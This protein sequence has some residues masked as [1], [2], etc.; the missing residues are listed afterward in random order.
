[1][2]A[3]LPVRQRLAAHRA[4]AT[5]ASCHNL[6][7][8]IGLALENFDAVGRW[9]DVE[10]GLPVDASGGLPDGTVCV[11]VEELEQGL[12][13]RPEVFVGT[14]V[15][16]LLT[17]ALGRGMESCDA[18]SVRQIIRDAEK[19]NYRFSS[20]IVG[21]ANSKSFQMRTTP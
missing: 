3:D 17:Y 6:I 2:A 8:P 15:E 19:A 20:L 13:K 1:M 12:L 16:N 7:D 21:I 14:L 4:N 18:P 11:G 5:C 10:A 9:R